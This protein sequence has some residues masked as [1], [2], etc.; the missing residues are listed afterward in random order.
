M[1]NWT[2]KRT[3]IFD[4]LCNFFLLQN[5]KSNVELSF[6]KTFQKTLPKEF[7]DKNEKV[8]RLRHMRLNVRISLVHFL[9]HCGEFCNINDTFKRVIDILVN[10]HITTGILLRITRYSH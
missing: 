4:P 8:R 6:L 1:S 5:T 10:W 7:S 3:D 2:F 9:Q